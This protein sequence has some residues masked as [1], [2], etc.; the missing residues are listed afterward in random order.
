MHFFLH[1]R[2]VHSLPF[3]INPAWSGK[4]LFLSPK[5]FSTAK[6]ERRVPNILEC[7]YKIMFNKIHFKIKK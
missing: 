1:Q 7:W 4:E 3:L 6:I 5:I 2:G